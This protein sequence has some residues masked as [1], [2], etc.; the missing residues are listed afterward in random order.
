MAQRSKSCLIIGVGCGSLVLIVGLAAGIFFYKQAQ[1][2]GE[3]FKDPEP[4]TLQVLGTDALPPGYYASFAMKIPFIMEMSIISNQ[5]RNEWQEGEDADNDP[6]LG[7]KG[8]IYISFFFR[9]KKQQELQDYFEG[10]T[11]DPDVLRENNINVDTKEIIDRGVFQLEDQSFLY[12]TQR[13]DI[14]L[15][16][17]R[18]EDGIATILLVSC[19]SD[20]KTRMAILYEPDP[21][22]S[23][24]LTDLDLT[25]TI[26]DINEVK[27]FMG[28]FKFCK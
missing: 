4:R 13:G 7:N 15:D 14:N 20:T 8:M 1:S 27:N 25:G 26:C 3:D 12:F 22:P 28:Y 6:K 10:K 18:S 5:P 2:F 23:A 9:G 21:D 19:E 16:Q 11:N 17:G 24:A